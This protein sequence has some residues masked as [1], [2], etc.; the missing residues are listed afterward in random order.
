[1]YTQVII[2]YLCIMQSYI[3]ICNWRKSTYFINSVEILAGGIGYQFTNLMLF[4][5]TPLLYR[6]SDFVSRVAHS[7]KQ[8]KFV[9]FSFCGSYFMRFKAIDMIFYITKSRT[10]LYVLFLAWWKMVEKMRKLDYRRNKNWIYGICQCT[11]TLWLAIYVLVFS[12]IHVSV[13]HLCQ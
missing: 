7:A 11:I 8:G 13:Y 12:S 3:S 10:F 4:V 6:I 1:M 9:H 2:S 5:F